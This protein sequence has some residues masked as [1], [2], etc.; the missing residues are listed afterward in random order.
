M[1]FSLLL[2]KA[3]ASGIDFDKFA[4]GHYARVSYDETVKRFI[5]QKG[6]DRKKD[7]SY[8][9]GLLSQE[10]LARVVFPLGTYTKE[11]VKEIAKTLGFPAYFKKESQDFYSGDYGELLDNP[12]HTGKIVRKDGTVLGA[13]QG[14]C[15]FTIGQRRGIGVA[16]NVPLYVTGINGETNTVTVGP[17]ED[18]LG[19][20]LIVRDVNWIGIESITSPLRVQAKIRYMHEAREAVISRAPDGDSV[21][22][23]FSEAQRAITPGQYAVFYDGDNVIGA[24]VIERTM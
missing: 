7:Q 8:F 22:V 20:R 11:K 10:Q 2:E 21:T 5:L 4:T 17:D 18:L 15:N 24:G 12:P 9:L 6:I 19:K 23:E 3:E 16:S 1:K 14:V 13:H